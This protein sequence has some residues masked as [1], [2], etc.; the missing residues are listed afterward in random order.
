[1][2]S[3]ADTVHAVPDLDVLQSR[4]RS[5]RYPDTVTH[6]S[7]HLVSRLLSDLQEVSGAYMLIK[8]Q[9]KASQSRLDL[10]QAEL[11]PLRK[12]NLRLKRENNDLHAE[13]IRLREDS[14]AALRKA[15]ALRKS[16][17]TQLSEWK[18]VSSQMQHKNVALEKER[19][20]LKHRLDMSS[21]S[22]VRLLSHMDL[23]APLSTGSA[24]SGGSVSGR[25]STV[26]PPRVPDQFSI[27]VVRMADKKIEQ[28]NDEITALRADNS[29]LRQKVSEIS[30]TLRVRDGELARIAQQSAS[31]VAL[32]GLT[33]K[34]SDAANAI[35]LT[36][37]LDALRSQL[38][39]MHE[40]CHRLEKERDSYVEGKKKVVAELRKIK[41]VTDTKA[42]EVAEMA[43][44]LDSLKTRNLQLQDLLTAAEERCDGLE[45][46]ALQ[47]EEEC[48][49]RAAESRKLSADKQQLSFDLADRSKRIGLLEQRIQELLVLAE[50]SKDQGDADDNEPSADVPVPVPAP[51][52]T[53]A[54]TAVAALAPAAVSNSDAGS[55]TTASATAAAED[56]SKTGK[57][58]QFKE[59]ATG[60]G[61]LQ[62]LPATPDQ[63]SII[64]RPYLTELSS[65]KR[66]L[67]VRSA[68]LDALRTE[69]LQLHETIAAADA[70]KQ[71][72][73]QTQDRDHATATAEADRVQSENAALRKTIVDLDSRQDKLLDELD[74]LSEKCSHLQQERSALQREKLQLQD[75]LGVL[76]HQ[77]AVVRKQGQTKDE[78]DQQMRFR[79]NEVRSDRDGLALEVE[80]LRKQLTAALFDLEQARREVTAKASALKE[81]SAEASRLSEELRCLLKEKLSLG[82]KLKDAEQEQL[83][84]LNQY[85]SAAAVI[86]TVR[87][88]KSNVE[89]ALASQAQREES[90]RSE[91]AQ[92]RERLQRGE[93][94]CSRFLSDLKDYEFQCDNLARICE[95][96]KRKAQSGEERESALMRDLESLRHLLA[97]VESQLSILQ[98]QHA[99]LETE[100]AHLRVRVEQTSGENAVLKQTIDAS[101]RTIQSL[102]GLS[103]TLRREKVQLETATL[104]QG[105]ELAQLRKKTEEYQLEIGRLRSTLT[106]VP[107]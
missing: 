82:E 63:A 12:E 104:A 46:R 1:M 70:H 30:Q 27:D 26:V 2:A 61:D 4:L 100:N 19:D 91:L 62:P 33:E 106:T 28:L 6:E 66:E 34:N 102:E 72:Q 67:A 11:A 68:E 90:L 105:T 93:A 42:A 65:L 38:E 101:R 53:R 17:E 10:T 75:S 94:D 69:M 49:L 103:E 21:Q 58:V 50:Q 85:R 23:V 8:D 18:F 57:S 89:R 48:E 86:D 36:A 80:D 3:P 47:L 83:A 96:L 41:E 95:A 84:I 45:L 71:E 22:G 7:A 73:E 37:D 59:A 13:T 52:P 44:E 60:S 74:K 97:Q 76:E 16:L 55:Q 25:S 51:L 92:T 20:A 35:A 32:R 40:T 81:A 54:A 14:D 43:A 98:R 29:N 39:Y 24:A 87:S 9:Q 107:A 64:L 31:G 15:E 79:M 5:L 88:E 99:S 78:A 56:P 77:L